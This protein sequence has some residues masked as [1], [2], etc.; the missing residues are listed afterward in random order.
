MKSVAAALLALLLTGCGEGG[1]SSEPKRPTGSRPGSCSWGGCI[2]EVNK[3]LHDGRLLVC[4]VTTDG[5]AI[6]CDWADPR[7]SKG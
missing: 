6:S 4:V 7:E 1:S 2:H 5:K 3:K